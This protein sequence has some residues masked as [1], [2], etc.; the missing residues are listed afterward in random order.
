MLYISSPDFAFQ[1]EQDTVL[2]TD[3]HVYGEYSV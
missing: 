1:N 2:T 3:K